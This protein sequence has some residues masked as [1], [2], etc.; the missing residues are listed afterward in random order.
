MRDQIERGFAA[1]GHLVYRRAGLVIAL[2]TPTYLPP[3]P[4]VQSGVTKI[5]CV[6]PD[7][8]GCGPIR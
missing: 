7:L 8:V 3:T 5:A 2:G 6:L 1:W 4:P